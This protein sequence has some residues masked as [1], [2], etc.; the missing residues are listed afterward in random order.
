MVTLPVCPLPAGSI[1]ARLVRYTL[2]PPVGPS[3]PPCLLSRLTA[4][5]PSRDVPEG[6][7]SEGDDESPFP[8]MT[9]DS[10]HIIL[11]H[12]GGGEGVKKQE[13]PEVPAEATA[14]LGSASPRR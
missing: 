8:A 6:L 14:A 3:T 13:D 10:R 11:V 4:S 7:G 1:F 9:T 12:A 5:G 2:A